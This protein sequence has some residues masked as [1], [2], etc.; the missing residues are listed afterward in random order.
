MIVSACPL[1]LYLSS[2]KAFRCT[3]CFALTISDAVDAWTWKQQMQH[4]ALISVTGKLSV[5]RYLVLKRGC[6]VRSGFGLDA[7]MRISSLRQDRPCMGCCSCQ[8]MC[9]LLSV[10][11][12]TFVCSCERARACPSASLDSGPFA[13]LL[14]HYCGCACA[15][16]DVLNPCST[17]YRSFIGTRSVFLCPGWRPNT[18]KLSS[19]RCSNPIPLIP[20]ARSSRTLNQPESLKG[21]K[22]S[23]PEA[24]AQK[25][26]PGA[27]L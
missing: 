15:C 16:W 3:L 20:Q 19:Q 7:C 18:S 24:Q 10:C 5:M 17:P 2:S 11:M 14:A 1:S 26:S 12:C 22:A 8:F 27:S 13:L 9:I 4:T 6:V 23:A 21:V 25:N